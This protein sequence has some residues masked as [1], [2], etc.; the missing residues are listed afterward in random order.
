MV[1]LDNRL[2]ILHCSA[3]SIQVVILMLPL[4]CPF[5]FVSDRRSI[6]RPRQAP[7]PVLEASILW[8]G[9]V[10]YGVVWCS[11]AWFGVVWR[12]VVWCG[13]VWCGVVWCGVVWCGVV[14]E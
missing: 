11:V 1:V 7:T 13:V 12:G 5:P 6:D 10:W 3:A 8:L 4:F 9:V 2:L 14:L